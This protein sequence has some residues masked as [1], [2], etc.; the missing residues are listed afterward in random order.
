MLY[1]TL[2]EH[3]IRTGKLGVGVWI[4]AGLALEST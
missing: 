2:V 4:E 1:C 3:V